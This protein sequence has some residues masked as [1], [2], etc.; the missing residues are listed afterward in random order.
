MASTMITLDLTTDNPDEKP[1]SLPVSMRMVLQWEKQFQG[2]SMGML[3]DDNNIK[4]QYLYEIAF[5]VAQRKG[6]GLGIPD[7]MTF[8]EFCDRYDVT[9][10][11]DNEDETD[12]TQAVA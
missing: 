9:P 3:N 1:I 5:V 4:A 7:G 11:D 2:R 8:S 12:P 6:A 10:Q